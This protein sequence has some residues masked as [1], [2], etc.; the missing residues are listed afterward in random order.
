M[1]PLIAAL[2]LASLVVACDARPVEP[3]NGNA[4]QGT[5]RTGRLRCE[6]GYMFLKLGNT[7]VCIPFKPP[8]P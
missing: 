7:P 5:D 6:P 4:L 3:D 8:L 1:K 2:V